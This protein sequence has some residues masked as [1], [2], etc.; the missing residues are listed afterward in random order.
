MRISLQELTGQVAQWT[1]RPVVPVAPAPAAP[2]PAAPVPAT[3]APAEAV[4]APAPVEALPPDARV[5]RAMDHAAK[6]WHLDITVPASAVVEAARLMDRTGFALDAV[7]GVD[8]IAESAMEVIYDYFHPE[9]GWRVAVRCRV[10]REG[11]EV[12]T[13]CGVFPGANWHERETHELL[14][15]G[16]A[17]HPNLIQLLLPEDATFHPLRKDYQP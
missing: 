15:I 7:T 13:V 2:A 14:G 8:W 1:G 3:G 17:G 12:P 9:S 10:A 5:A 11:A 4:P 6:G 16:F